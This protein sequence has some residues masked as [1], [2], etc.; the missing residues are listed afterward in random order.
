MAG[1]LTHLNFNAENVEPSD[2]YDPLPAGEYAVVITDSEWKATKAGNGQYLNLRLDVIEGEYQGRVIYDLLNLQNPNPKATEIAQ[3][4]LSQICRAVG[5]MAPQDTV[6]LHDKPMVAK[7]GI[8]PP[9]DGYDAKNKVK[10]YK[11]IGSPV[12]SAPAAPAAGSA[13][14]RP[15]EK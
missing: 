11:P 5:V 7:V 14:K 1:N 6:E 9:R 13:P 15:W 12:T 10:A 4:T 2:S 8:E 3:K